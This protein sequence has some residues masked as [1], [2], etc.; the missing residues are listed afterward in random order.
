MNLDI[1]GGTIY[2]QQTHLI[3][4]FSTLCMV[5]TI[6]QTTIFNSTEIITEINHPLLFSNVVQQAPAL[7]GT[8]VLPVSVTLTVT[9]L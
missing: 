9:S 5:V 7:S 2:K 1:F 8:V 3:K 4:V 6:L